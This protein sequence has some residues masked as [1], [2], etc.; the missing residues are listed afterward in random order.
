M[1]AERY[2]ALVALVRR[3]R[4]DASNPLTA[5]LGNVQLL[6]EDSALQDPEVREGL[7][8]VEGELRRLAEIL[9]RLNDVRDEPHVPGPG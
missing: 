3:V 1:D 5:A 9:R 2:G 8:V 7:T 4:H 6:L